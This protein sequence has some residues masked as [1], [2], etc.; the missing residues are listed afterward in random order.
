MA[1][2]LHAMKNDNVETVLMAD[3][4]AAQDDGILFSVAPVW[5]TAS[6]AQQFN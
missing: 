2:C 6:V 4:G 3:M 5:A 1:L